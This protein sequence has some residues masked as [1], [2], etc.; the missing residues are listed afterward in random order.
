MLPLVLVVE[1]SHLV[2][3][4]A[5]IMEDTMVEVSPLD[6]LVVVTHRDHLVLLVVAHLDHQVLDR[7]APLEV[8][9]VAAAV[10]VVDHTTHQPLIHHTIPNCSP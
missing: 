5:D 6:H 7:Q 3:V 1:V 4:A 9:E 2:V 8:A 10:V